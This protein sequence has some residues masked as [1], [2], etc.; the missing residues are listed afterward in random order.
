MDR[1]AKVM[2]EFKSRSDVNV[3]LNAPPGVVGDVST[4]SNGPTN[5]NVGQNMAFGAG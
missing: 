1:E 2:Q 4:R 5:F 3:N